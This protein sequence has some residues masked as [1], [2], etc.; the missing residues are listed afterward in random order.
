MLFCPALPFFVIDVAFFVGVA[1][2]A[3]TETTWQGRF[4]IFSRQFLGE[5][6]MSDALRSSLSCCV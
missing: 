1:A 2:E 3:D 4:F 5:N 6:D